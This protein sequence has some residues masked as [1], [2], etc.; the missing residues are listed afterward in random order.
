MPDVRQLPPLLRLIDDASLEVRTA[1]IRELAGFGDGLEAALRAL[2][3]PPD[4]ETIANAL[5]TVARQREE[6]QPGIAATR[7]RPGDSAPRYADGQLVRHKRYG[8]RGVVVAMDSSCRAPDAWYRN[9]RTQPDRDQPWYH[10][11]VDAGDQVTYAA[12]SSLLPDESM[13][14]IRHPFTDHFFDAFED[15]RYRRND[16][17]WPEFEG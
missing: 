4:E 16:R 1:V 14:A 11:L 12:Q 5:A 17:P 13:E 3:S 10:V 6:A 8:Y 9:N 15:G 7:P 2:P